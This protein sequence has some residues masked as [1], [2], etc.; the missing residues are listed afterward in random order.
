MAHALKRIYRF[1][2]FVPYYIWMVLDSNVKVIR[3][4]VTTKDYSEPAIIKV[5][6]I[7]KSN[8]GF[9]MLANLISMTPGTVSLDLSEDRK[10]LF[11]HV[12]FYDRDNNG[13]DIR[14]DMDALQHKIARIFE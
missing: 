4:V 14:N 7:L 11:V 5:P 13:A 9:F 8:F 6:L 1:L 12:M 3:D 10:F 2:L